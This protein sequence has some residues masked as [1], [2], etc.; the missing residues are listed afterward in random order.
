MD[1]AG[2][3]LER[4]WS[5]EERSEERESE[6]ERGRRREETEGFVVRRYNMTLSLKC[7]GNK[8]RHHERRKYVIYAD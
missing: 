3:R 4:K 7:M 6:K 5:E 1:R 2:R 8:K